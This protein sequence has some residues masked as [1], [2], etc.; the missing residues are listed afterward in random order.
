MNARNERDGETERRREE[1]RVRRAGRVV[2]EKRA[3]F[4]L[5]RLESFA[6]SRVCRDRFAPASFAPSL[7]RD[8]A[9]SPTNAEGGSASISLTTSN[10]PS[11]ARAARPAAAPCAATRSL[12][13]APRLPASS[14]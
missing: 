6:P 3:S 2:D 14:V 7:L 8:Y 4:R 1:R 13:A 12:S 5:R 10:C 11:H 9:P